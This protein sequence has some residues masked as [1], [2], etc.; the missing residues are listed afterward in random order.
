MTASRSTVEDARISQTDN[1]GRNVRSGGGSGALGAGVLAN[2]DLTGASGANAVMLSNSQLK[3]A[4]IDQ[5]RNEADTLQ[6]LG[7]T[8][9]ANSFNLGDYQGGL[10]VVDISGELRGNLLEQGREIA[11]VATGDAKGFVPNAPLTWGAI[12]RNGYVYSSDMNS[13]LWV[14]KVEQGGAVTP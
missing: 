10:R 1:T 5:Q 14:V 4:R 8:A 6:S 13:G 9:L 11:H 12:Y 3:G 2:M 7:G